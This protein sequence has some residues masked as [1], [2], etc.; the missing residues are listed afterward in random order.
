MD[1]SLPDHSKQAKRP[2]CE[3]TRSSDLLN[4][5]SSFEPSTLNP[6]PTPSPSNGSTQ[7]IH[8]PPR[9]QTNSG[10]TSCGGTG[11]CQVLTP[12]LHRRRE[13]GK[14]AWRTSIGD[15]GGGRAFLGTRMACPNSR[16]RD[17]KWTTEEPWFGVKRSCP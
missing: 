6:R 10:C 13:R 7:K 9:L 16:G 17:E 1:H 4:D 5:Q 8:K 12:L 14:A 11:H 3:R 2:V 15:H